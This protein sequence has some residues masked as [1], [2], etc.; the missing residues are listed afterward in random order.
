MSNTK[1]QSLRLFTVDQQS[2]FE[3]DTADDVTK[4][5]F[6]DSDGAHKD[7]QICQLTVEDGVN[8]ADKLTSLMHADATETGRAIAREDQISA[9][10]TSLIATERMRAIA[11]EFRLQSVIDANDA[12]RVQHDQ[13]VTNVLTGIINTETARAQEAE[14]ENAS[15]IAAET[16]R[17]TTKEADITNALVTEETRAQLSEQILTTAIQTEKTRAEMKEIELGASIAEESQRASDAETVLSADVSDLTSSLA[18]E[19]QRATDAESVLSSL[20]MQETTRATAAE[21]EEK[22]RA[23]G[24]ENALQTQISYMSHNLDPVALDSLTEIVAKVNAVDSSI[25]SRIYT[26]EKFLRCHFDLESLYPLTISDMKQMVVEIADSGAIA[27]DE[28]VPVHCVEGGWAFTNS[29]HITSNKIN[30]YLHGQDVGSDT[31]LGE[32]TGFYAKVLLKSVGSLPF[33]SVYTKQKGDGT[34]AGSWYGSR[35]TFVVPSTATLTAGQEV[36]LYTGADLPAAYADIPHVQLELDA[37][38]S[39]GSDHE[40]QALLTFALSTDS[41]APK[42]AVSLCLS[43]FM[44]G[45][46]KH[47]HIAFNSNT[48]APSDTIEITQTPG[49]FPNELWSSITTGADGTGDVVWQQGPSMFVD[50]GELASLSVTVPLNTQLYFNA[51]DSYGDSW[52]GS[53]YELKYQGNILINNNGVSPTDDGSGE[54]EMSEGFILTV[55]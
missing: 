3:V 34:D 18:V 38:S 39:N 20:I 14:T 12:L 41:A 13:A 29:S 52:N 44:F 27:A 31:T 37:S 50:G 1:A 4:V 54:L 42:N 23:L 21:L 6:T 5:K 28:G 25:F 45:D 19:V 10:S 36:L 49:A 15:A 9:E 26:V 46:G 40:D 47:T 51:Y 24:S 32:Y 55:G 53:L 16:S 48:P 43:D 8:V 33:F 2:T 30:W 17:A 35:R 7:V 11:E 22:T